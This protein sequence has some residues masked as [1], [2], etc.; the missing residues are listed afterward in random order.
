MIML[1]EA[2]RKNDHQQAA[3]LYLTIWTQKGNKCAKY[4]AEGTGFGFCSEVS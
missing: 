1:H 3:P 4:D 2:M